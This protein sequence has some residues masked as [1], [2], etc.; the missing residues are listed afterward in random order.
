DQAGHR[1]PHA[2]GIRK[3]VVGGVLECTLD[4]GRD[5]VGEVGQDARY[6]WETASSIVRVG[7]WQ[8]SCEHLVGDT[9]QRIEVRATVDQPPVELLWRH[10]AWCPQAHAGRGSDAV[11]TT[12]DFRDPE[13]EHF[14]GL[15]PGSNRNH[16]VG[17]FEITVHDA[18]CMGCHQRLQHMVHHHERLLCGERPTT[19]Q[20][21]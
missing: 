7:E 17:G 9:A 1:V 19:E 3:S 10:V 5:C 16:D 21:L 18:V 14:D 6:R 4:H 8:R 15:E 13:V 20:D 12:Q 11:L 2:A